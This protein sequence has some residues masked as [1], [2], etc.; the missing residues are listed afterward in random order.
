M[1][2]ARKIFRRGAPQGGLLLPRSTAR[3]GLMNWPKCAICMRAVDAYRLVR[4]TDTEV[5]IEA[6][7]DGVRI[8]PSSGLAVHGSAMMHPS[9]KSSI[10]INKGAGWSAN[11]FT[12]IVSRLAFFAPDAASE[13]REFTQD[14]SASGVHKKPTV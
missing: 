8:D 11:R 10:T 3:H 6:R 2:F 1:S 5:E 7:C 4:D 13:G 14:T 9:M 12:D